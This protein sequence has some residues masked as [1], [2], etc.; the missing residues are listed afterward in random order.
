MSGVGSL[1][2]ESFCR[3]TA[4]GVSN[5]DGGWCMD[6]KEHVLV[7]LGGLSIRCTLGLQ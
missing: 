6:G 4:F 2:G 5:G 1:M 3:E 7:V